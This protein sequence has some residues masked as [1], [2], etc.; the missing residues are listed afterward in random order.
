MDGAEADPQTCELGKIFLMSLALRMPIFNNLQLKGEMEKTKISTFYY[1]KS[2][3]FLKNSCPNEKPVAHSDYEI[4]VSPSK[5]FILY[6]KNLIF[7]QPFRSIFSLK[8]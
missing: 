3:I 2:G 5:P 4:P 1:N 7:G 8:M 6:E